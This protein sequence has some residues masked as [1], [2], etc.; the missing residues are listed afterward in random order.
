VKAQ[1]VRVLDVTFI[2]PLLMFAAR[3][4]RSP[5]LS[6]ALAFVGVATILYNAE[7]YIAGSR[8]M[9]KERGA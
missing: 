4:V 9:E 6:A 2:G 8:N 1:E 3:R 7:N 5:G